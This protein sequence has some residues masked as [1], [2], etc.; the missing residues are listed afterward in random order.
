MKPPSSMKFHRRCRDQ[1]LRSGALGQTL[2]QMD[3]D[4]QLWLIGQ[5]WELE[6]TAAEFAR[7]LII[8]AYDEDQAKGGKP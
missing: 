8:D 4:V 6:I 3:D 2:A 1:D 7:A 5:M